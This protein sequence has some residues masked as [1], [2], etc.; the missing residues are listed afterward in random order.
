MLP[1]SAWYQL[2]PN[3]IPLARTIPNTFGFILH[4][5]GDNFNGRIATPA[6]GTWPADT[7]V[8]IRC[9]F[10]HRYSNAIERHRVYD[11]ETLMSCSFGNDGPL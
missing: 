6:N 11:S 4:P 9:Q 5:P 2:I 7:W 1:L 8:F 10:D 3:Q